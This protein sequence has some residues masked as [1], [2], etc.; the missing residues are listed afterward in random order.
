MIS[1]RIHV[2]FAVAM[3]EIVETCK[4]SWPA[5]VDVKKLVG[6]YPLVCEAF[7]NVFIV[8]AGIFSLT[9]DC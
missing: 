8:F 2:P 5:C 3:S 9:I 7:H 1:G 6:A 4:Y